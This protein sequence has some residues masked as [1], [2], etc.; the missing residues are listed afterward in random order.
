MTTPAEFFVD[1]ISSQGGG[2]STKI[3]VPAGMTVKQFFE[4]KFE[5][6]DP[7]AFLIRINREQVPNAAYELQPNDLISVT[8]NKV[9]GAIAA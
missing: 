2:F 6:Q 9:A 5:N 8:P 7:K 4:R 3:K 1:F